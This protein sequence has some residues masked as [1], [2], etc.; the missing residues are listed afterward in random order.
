MVLKDFI[1]DNAVVLP[2]V[3]ISICRFSV[4]LLDFQW[5]KIPELVNTFLLVSP[6]SN[7]WDSALR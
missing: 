2:E 6:L 3:E 4:S 5:A 7:A 1:F